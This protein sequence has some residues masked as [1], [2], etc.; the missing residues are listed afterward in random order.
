MTFKQIYKYAP[1]GRTFLTLQPNTNHA[2]ISLTAVNEWFESRKVWIYAD[3]E[4]QKIAFKP[5]DD[6]SAYTISGVNG[7]SQITQRPILAPFGIDLEETTQIELD[8]DPESGYIIGDM[9]TLLSS[10]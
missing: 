8:T 4:N 7:S 2:L 3:I 5:T 6:E 1:A 10:E 9:S